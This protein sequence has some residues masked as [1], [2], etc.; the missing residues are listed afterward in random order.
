MASLKDVARL[1]SVSLMTVSRAINNPELLKPDTLKQVQDAIDALNY[2]PDFSARKIRGKG[3]KKLSTL[4]VLALDTATTPFSVEIIFSIEQVA[5][6]FGWSSFIVN[7]SSKDDFSRAIRQI[8]SQRPDGII[9]TSM[10]LREIEIPEVLFDK[11]LVLSNCI[12]LKQNFPTYIPDDF[13][14]QYRAVKQLIARGYRRPL[15]IYLPE[16]AVASGIRRRAVHHAWT[17]DNLSLDLLIQHHMLWGDEHYRD[18]ISIIEQHCPDNKPQ[19]DSIICGND[20]IAF[21]AYQVLMSKGIKIPDQVGVLGFDNMIG[22][23]ELFYPPLTTVQLPH[24]ELG[25]E[26]ALHIIEDRQNLNTVLLP[27]NF[28]NRGS[29]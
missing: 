6:R 26:A 17:E 7:I 14:G 24:Y 5:R 23:G 4:G 27:C 3:S 9:L 15:C 21:L 22:T 20:R 19:F 11:K 10:G 29:L 25:K 12:D 8:L 2:I 13:N 1:A 28:L 16:K 18:V